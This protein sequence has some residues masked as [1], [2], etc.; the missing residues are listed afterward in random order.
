MPEL[1]LPGNEHDG[2]LPKDRCDS[3]HGSSLNPLLCPS[4]LPVF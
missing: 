2:T 1:N 4:Y 3:D